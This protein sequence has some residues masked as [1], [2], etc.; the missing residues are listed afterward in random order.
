MP[1]CIPGYEGCKFTEVIGWVTPMIP[2]REVEIINFLS[3]HTISK[4]YPISVPACPGLC[5]RGRLQLVSLWLIYSV[6]DGID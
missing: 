4:C 2:W 5:I 6:G 1:T 3:R